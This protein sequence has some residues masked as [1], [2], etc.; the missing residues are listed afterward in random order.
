MKTNNIERFSG[1]S[2]K[3]VDKASEK[4]NKKTRPI[5]NSQP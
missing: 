1:C 5:L 3:N 2:N 4:Y